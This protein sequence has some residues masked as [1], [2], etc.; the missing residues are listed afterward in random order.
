MRLARGQQPGAPSLN[1]RG[2]PSQ[3]L[4]NLFDRCRCNT[5]HCWLSVAEAMAAIHDPRESM[6]LLNTKFAILCIYFLGA[7]LSVACNSAAQWA[8]L[9]WFCSRTQPFC[10]IGVVVLAVGVSFVVKFAWD[11][12]VV[13]RSSQA[14]A[15]RRG[16]FFLASSL[17]ITGVYFVV[18]SAL[19]VSGISNLRLVQASWLFFS[20]GYLTKYFLDK[21]FAFRVD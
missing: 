3:Q 20:F 11:N 14:S 1:Q 13:F 7:F 4:I 19:A 5:L 10:R 12:I 17:M 9:G 16:V 6:R 15:K 18:M 2:F 8:L 21:R